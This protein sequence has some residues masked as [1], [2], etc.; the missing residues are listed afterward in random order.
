M[1][2]E[3]AV[4]SVTLRSEVLVNV[5]NWVYIWGHWPVL[6]TVMVWLATRH[7]VQF[8]R[9]RNAMFV[10]G[11]IGLVIFATYPVAPP[12]LTMHGYIDTVTERS[13]AYHALQPPSLVNPYAAMPSLH[14]G[15]D[16]LAGIAVFTA[17]GLRRMRTTILV[18]MPKVPSE[19]TNTPA[20]S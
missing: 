1:A 16:L 7:R 20:R 15:W 9:L 3:D 19:P 13:S 14:V 4:Q 6:I 5:A 10:S 18:A 11:G 2:W 12:R 8:L 17:A